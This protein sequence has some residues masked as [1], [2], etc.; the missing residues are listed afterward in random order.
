MLKVLIKM[1]ALKRKLFAMLFGLAFLL[2]TIML[3][4][5]TINMRQ[6]YEYSNNLPL[7]NYHSIE[8]ATLTRSA[9]QCR[10]VKYLSFDEL[11]LSE[12]TS[13]SSTEERD[14]FTHPPPV[15][16]ILHQSWKD[17]QLP[18]RFK[19]WSRTWCE[20]FPDWTHVLWSDVDNERFVKQ[21]Y[22]WF[23][24]RYRAFNKS[25]SRADA[26]RYLY[27]HRFGGLYADLDTICLRPFESHLAHRPIVLGDMKARER[28]TKSTHFYYI[29]NSV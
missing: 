21:Q 16:R 18:G 11:L 28:Q 26:V 7:L 29:Q 12:S 19:R 17:K 15:T 20:C 22:S 24:P 10:P 23:L 5:I 3:L 14:S 1:V 4:K 9:K 25:I 13:I 27:L 8:K 2:L 6:Y